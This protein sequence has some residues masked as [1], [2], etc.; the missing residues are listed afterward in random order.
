MIGLIAWQAGSAFT[1]VWPRWLHCLSERTELPWLT[2]PCERAELPITAFNSHYSV[3]YYSLVT[4]PQTKHAVRNEGAKIRKRYNVQNLLFLHAEHFKADGAHQ[5]VL[6]NSELWSAERS[7]ALF[8]GQPR[9]VCSTYRK[10]SPSFALIYTCRRSVATRAIN[11]TRK[12]YACS[13]KAVTEYV[14]VSITR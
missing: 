8:S 10:A 1:E 9:S 11:V 2:D 13:R 7:I 14:Y 3:T 6:S 12:T 5:H 4:D